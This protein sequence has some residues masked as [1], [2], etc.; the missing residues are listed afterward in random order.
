MIN[1][2]ERLFEDEELSTKVKVTLLEKPWYIK[3]RCE[4]KV[5]TST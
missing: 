1:E 3:V 4:N 5:V 2:T